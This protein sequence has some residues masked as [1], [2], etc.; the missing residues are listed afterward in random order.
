MDWIPCNPPRYVLDGKLLTW[1]TDINGE[2][3]GFLH[4]GKIVEIVG[5]EYS[6]QTTSF[7]LQDKDKNVSWHL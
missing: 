6:E 7:E 4:L 2:E 1:Y 3:V 5:D